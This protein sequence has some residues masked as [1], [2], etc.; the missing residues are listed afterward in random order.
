M[1]G[2]GHAHS[3]LCRC[4]NA[5]AGGGRRAP[6]RH[7]SA[8][9]GFAPARRCAEG[10]ARRAVPVQESDHRRHGSPLLDLR[11]SAIHERDS[12]QRARV[13]GRAAGH[14][15][16]R[17]AARPAGARES[18]SQEGHSRHDRHLHHARAAWR[19]VPGGSRHRKPQQSSRRVRLAHRHLRA[20]HRRGN[21]AR[22]LA[23]PTT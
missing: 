7:L 2:L 6:A 12:R 14:Q 8:R 16:D 13:S 18:D 4:A 17:V 10:E 19:Y 5:A 15:P 9:P 20:L 1:G 21:A 23:R 22:K 11:A 3:G